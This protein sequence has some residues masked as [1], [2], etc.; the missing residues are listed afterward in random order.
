[1]IYSP[2][3]INKLNAAAREHRKQTYR[4]LL[5]DR[6]TLHQPNFLNGC[7]IKYLRMISQSYKLIQTFIIV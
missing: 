4:K 1:M 3:F 5:V 7:V 6:D 2:Y